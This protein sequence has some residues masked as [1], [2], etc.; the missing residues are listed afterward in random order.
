MRKEK[1]LCDVTLIKKQKTNIYHGIDI[2]KEFADE[3]LNL[4]LS[5]SRATEYK[6]GSI[7]FTPEDIL[8]EN[9]LHI[10]KS[11]TVNLFQMNA[12]GKRIITRRIMPGSI[13]GFLVL[14]GQNYDGNFAEAVIDSVTYKITRKD[15]LDLLRAKTEITFKIIEALVNVLMIIEKRFVEM[16]YSPVSVRIAHFLIV[17]EEQATGELKGITH[18]EIGEMVGAARQTVTEVLNLLQ[19]KGLIKLETKK[20]RIIDRYRLARVID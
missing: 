20:I 13:F 10:L 1:L 14:S 8:T 7:I 2:F 12:H 19:K 15:V 16:A 18:E 6:A 9:C 11:G 17:N 4:L 3:E 5:K